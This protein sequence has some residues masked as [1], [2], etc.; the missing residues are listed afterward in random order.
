MPKGTTALSTG[1]FNGGRN[2]TDGN[3]VNGEQS[4]EEI[5]NDV[6]TELQKSVPDSSAVYP[7]V[8]AEVTFPGGASASVDVAIPTG[9]WRV[10][11]AWLLSEGA[12]DT[13][14]TAKLQK[15]PA[16]SAVDITNA[17]DI[18]S[19]VDGT[20]LAPTT[21]NKSN[22]QLVGGTDQLRLTVADNAGNDAP[23]I[24]GYALLARVA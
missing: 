1:H 21:I 24:K 12:G 4:L 5:I 2:L 16:G 11:D 3:K 22:R 6:H 20:R 17:V 18:S 14:D 23:I 7:T 9:T 15:K 19:A 10:M 13:S 8:V